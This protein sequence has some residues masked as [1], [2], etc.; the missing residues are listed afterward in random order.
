MNTRLKIFLTLQCHLLPSA[1]F[2]FWAVTRADEQDSVLSKLKTKPLDSVCTLMVCFVREQVKSR[3][4]WT[5]REEAAMFKVNS[6]S[7]FSLIYC[8]CPVVN[9]GTWWMLLEILV[10]TIWKQVL[11]NPSDHLL[12]TLIKTHYL[13]VKSAEVCFY[14]EYHGFGFFPSQTTMM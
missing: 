12:A 5:H 4:V 14:W 13:L 8:V 11:K 6:E 10:L 3:K 2:V 9:M 1:T 7:Q